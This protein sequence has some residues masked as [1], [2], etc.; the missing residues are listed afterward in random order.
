MKKINWNDVQEANE[1]E[2]L[3][4]GGYECQILRVDDNEEK[5]YL[6]LEFDI[7]AGP[8]KDFFVNSCASLD[9]WP[10]STIKSY[11]QKALPFFK[12]MLT[13]V[14]NSNDGFSANS[15][16]DPSELINKKV[17]MVI[18]HE[19]Y[20]NGNGQKRTRIRVASFRSLDKIRKGD[21][22]IPELKIND[23]NKPEIDGFVDV[24]DT[25]DSDLPF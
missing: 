15:F 6:E 10:G 14:E 11:K 5:E 25:D 19:Q 16:S 20:W 23:Y 13:A 12:A 17:G 2:L 3:P 22:K 24:T 8:Q 1:F 21:F 7:C 4:A 9:W 18:G